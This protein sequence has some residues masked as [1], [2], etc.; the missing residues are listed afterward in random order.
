VTIH[1][2]GR[3]AVVSGVLRRQ[4]SLLVF[5]SARRRAVNVLRRRADEVPELVEPAR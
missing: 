2:S 4:A 1:I 5:T 3:A